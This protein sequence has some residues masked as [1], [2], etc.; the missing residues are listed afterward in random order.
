MTDSKAELAYQALFELLEDIDGIGEVSRRLREPSQVMQGQQPALYINETGEMIEP[1][2]GFE[3]TVASK[4]TLMCDL[5][6]YVWEGTQ[7]SPCSP[8]L[9]NMI[10]AVRDAIAPPAPSPYQEL[11]G[12]VSHCWISGKIEIIEG[13]INGQGMAIIPVNILTN[14]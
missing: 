4:Q 11:N 14:I 3:G 10:Q 7:E 5:Y 8:F 12:T 6:L 13:V 2:K 9:N 1:T